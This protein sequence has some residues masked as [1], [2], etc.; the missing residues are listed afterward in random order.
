MITPTP[1]PLEHKTM[2]P[3]LAGGGT[4]LPAHVGVLKALDELDIKIEHL[5]GVSGGSIVAALW[6][7]GWD[8]EHMKQ[9]S[10]DVDFTRFREFKLG[11]LL[12][13]GGLSSGDI[14]E[15]WMDEQLNGV[16]FEQL[17]KELHIVA[18]DVKNGSPVIFDRKTTPDFKVSTAV[19]YSMGIP[20]LFAFKK[21]KDH[22]MVDGSILAEDS[23]RRDWTGNGTTAC[24]FRLKANKPI[25]NHKR[26]SRL[27]PL[28]D[29]MQMLMKTFMSTISREFIN[30]AFWNTTIVINTDD[31]SPVEFNLSV[32]K[33][34]MLHDRGYKTTLDVLPMKLSQRASTH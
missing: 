13:H 34:L 4:R 31:I 32:E 19:R 16:T 28:A 7:S 26:I 27:F 11:Q 24:C 14:F 3:I 30:D 20:L 12:F 2:V 1:I 9:L 23:L 33:K 10:V 17:E 25:K 29:Y 5:V 15:K 18:T 8:I 21:Y 22:L 6:A